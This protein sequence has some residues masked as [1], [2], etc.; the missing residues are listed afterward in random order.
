VA[1]LSFTR[2]HPRGSYVRSYEGRCTARH[3]ATRYGTASHSS[4]KM[5]RLARGVA[6]SCQARAKSAAGY[7]RWSKSRK[8]ARRR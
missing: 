2:A 4:V 6:Y 8:L 3:H 5:K 7:G 1:Y